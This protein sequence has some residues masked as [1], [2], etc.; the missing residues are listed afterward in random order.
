MCHHERCL[1][2]QCQR[3]PVVIVDRRCLVPSCSARLWIEHKLH[4]V[5]QLPVNRGAVHG[6]SLTD[7]AT[8]C[9]PGCHRAGLTAG[10]LLMWRVGCEMLATVFRT[11]GQVRELAER[12]R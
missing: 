10:A 6:G 12:T 11:A 4:H 3:N 7:A 5:A 1:R 2:A 9:I 8:D